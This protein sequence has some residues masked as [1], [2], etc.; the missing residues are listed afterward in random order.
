LYLDLHLNLN[1]QIDTHNTVQAQSHMTMMILLVDTT[2]IQPADQ[3]LIETEKFNHLV[4]IFRL[5]HMLE[6]E[7][8]MIEQIV[9]QIILIHI[10][11]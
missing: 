4:K 6:F 1:N 10:I 9:T 2:T 7:A 3:N 5:S 8:N 11:I